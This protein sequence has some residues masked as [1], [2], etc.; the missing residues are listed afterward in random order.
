MPRRSP[1]VRCLVPIGDSTFRIPRVKAA[2]AVFTRC[3]LSPH[4]SHLIAIN[5]S[6]SSQER[7]S[8]HLSSSPVVVTPD[9]VNKWSLRFWL[10]PQRCWCSSS[11]CASSCCP[12]GRFRRRRFSKNERQNPDQVC[13]EAKANSSAALLSCPF[14]GNL[15]E[16]HWKKH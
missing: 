13:V 1:V 14:T 11:G 16:H 7:H 9:A 6:Q 4:P 8:N 2:R 15:W 3:R 12:V 5:K 10:Q